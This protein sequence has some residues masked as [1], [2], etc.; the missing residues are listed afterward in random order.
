M[1][2]ILLSFAL[3]LAGALL[4][5]CL[6]SRPAAARRAGALS[7]A[8]AAAAGLVPALLTLFS[9]RTETLLLPW[10]VPLGSFSLRLDP[11]SALFL[12]PLF[13]LTGLGAVYGAGYLKAYEGRKP[14]GL[15]WAAFNLLAAAML[16]VFTSA[17]ALLF[18]TGWEL[19][20]A[21]S[22]LLVLFEHEKEQARKAGFIYLAAGGAGALL[23]M[24][25]FALLASPSGSLE[26]SSFAAPAGAAAP[27]FLLA[28]AGFGLKAGFIPLHVWLPEAHPAAPSHVSAVMSGIMIKTGVY[29]LLRSFIWLVPADAIGHYPAATWGAAIAVLGTITLFV[30]TLQAL[31]QEET[32]RLLAFHSIGQVGYILLGLG[33][34]LAFLGAGAGSSAA[35]AAGKGPAVLALAGV[36]FAGAIFHTL[37]HGLFKSL[38]FLNA[39]SILHATDTQDLNRLGGL[40]KHMPLTA[41]TALV[42]SFSIAGVPLFNGFGSK[43]SIYVASIL[44]SREAGYLAVCGVLAIL[45][46]ALTLASF[47]K[48][49]GS[50]FLSP[51]S[52][53][54]DEKLRERGRL[55]VGPL[56]GLPQA[57]L[58][59]LCVLLGVAPAVAFGIIERALDGSR[60]G[61]GSALAGSGLAAGAG[62]A[63]VAAADG[64]AFLG[65]IVLAGVMAALFLLAWW[66]SRSGGAV[67]RESAPWLC[68]YVREAEVYRYGAHNL[69]IEFKRYFDWVG[70]KKRIANP[71][72]EEP[73][74]AGSGDPAGH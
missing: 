17:N 59:A 60:T 55:E 48:F 26:F 51:G 46:S 61:L 24:A 42:A 54:V 20:A 56:M 43:W 1:S 74:T 57:V 37:N 18:L 63:G 58:A 21:S 22:F 11:L 8:A 47:M 2:F 33:A 38:L 50:S 12:V 4:A 16:L 64:K 69:Y 19:M 65:P 39:G 28:L 29:G 68:G 30:G 27:V 13:L 23:L 49:F 66:L 40:A 45:T 6:N 71:R 9:S 67:R 5:L 15:A 44:G 7:A 14:L 32:K 53:L 25:M 10:R 31:K 70:G 35:D 36:A 62:T 3:L 41:V 73:V 52:R 34:C 72:R